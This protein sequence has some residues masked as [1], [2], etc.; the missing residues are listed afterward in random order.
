MYRERER[1]RKRENYPNDNRNT[2]C[3]NY[4]HVYINHKTGN[5]F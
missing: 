4:Y 2:L 5:A 3:N 1:E